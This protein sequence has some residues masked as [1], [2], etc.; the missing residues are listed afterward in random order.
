MPLRIAAGQPYDSTGVHDYG[1][2]AD[3]GRLQWPLPMNAEN[4]AAERRLFEDG[5]FFHAGGRARIIAQEPRPLPE[6][7]NAKYPFLLLTVRG[8]AA[9]W[10]TQTRTAKSAILRQLS[11]SELYVEANPR[12]AATLHIAAG[13]W[14]VVASQRGRVEARAVLTPTVQRASSCCRCTSRR[15]TRSPTPC[16]IPTRISRRIR[17]ARY[18]CGPWE[19]LSRSAWRVR[20]KSLSRTATHASTASA[21]EAQDALL[22]INRT[23]AGPVALAMESRCAAIPSHVLAG[24]PASLGAVES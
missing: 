13:Q 16:S 11:P 12:D 8:S 18:H 5:R 6:P 21:S 9:Q 14:V 3:R 7:P 23:S 19:A 17:R 20:F 24:V 15:P 22:L 2:L 4:Q 1:M 10:H